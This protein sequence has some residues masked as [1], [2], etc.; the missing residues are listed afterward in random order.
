VAV[1]KFSVSKENE[2]E[3]TYFKPAGEKVDILRRNIQE[4]IEKKDYI[5]AIPDH[6]KLV[7]TYKQHSNKTN[8]DYV[9]TLLMLTLE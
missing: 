6:K 2:S 7:S 1:E 3:Y 8:L 5:G 4:K 9:Y